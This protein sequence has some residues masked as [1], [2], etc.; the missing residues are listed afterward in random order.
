VTPAVTTWA[1]HARRA[2]E[3]SADAGA[4][5]CPA[6]GASLGRRDGPDGLG[7]GTPVL[8][9]HTPRDGRHAPDLLVCIPPARLAAELEAIRGA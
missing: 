5:L 7:W 4:V 8:R 2:L 9:C 6:C 1:E 3:S